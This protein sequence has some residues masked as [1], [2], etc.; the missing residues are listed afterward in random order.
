MEVQGIEN[1]NS[2]KRL[3]WDEVERDEEEFEILSEDLEN[4][5]DEAARREDF[6]DLPI[7]ALVRQIK[8][9][10]GLSGA[11][12]LTACE[13]PSPDSDE[14]RDLAFDTAPPNTG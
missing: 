7:D 2:L 1:L 3:M 14:G 8:S 11:L 10:M 4:R 12:R 6:L 9:D 5:L 13:A